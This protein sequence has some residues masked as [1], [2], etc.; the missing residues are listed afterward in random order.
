M[1]TFSIPAP[2]SGSTVFTKKIWK[3][4]GSPPILILEEGWTEIDQNTFS[5]ATTLLMIRIYGKHETKLQMIHRDA[6]RILTIQIKH[7]V[8]RK[9]A[10][11]IFMLT[12]RGQAAMILICLSPVLRSPVQYQMQMQIH[13]FLC[14][15]TM[16]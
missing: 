8:T 2:E 5:G 12:H 9:I 16:L 11:R 7:H 15:A 1:D 6:C 14:C 10:C 3:K 13:A 4:N